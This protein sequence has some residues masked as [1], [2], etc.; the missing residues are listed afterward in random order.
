MRYIE[1]IS[2]K[3]INIKARIY[4]GEKSVNE[5]IYDDI[6]NLCSFKYINGKFST[7]LSEED[8][9]DIFNIIKEINA[10]IMLDISKNSF[11]FVSNQELQFIMIITYYQ[12]FIEYE[13]YSSTVKSLD[14]PEKI[15]KLQIYSQTFSTIMDRSLLYFYIIG[16]K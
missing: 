15:S 1:E 9:K 12:G 10:Y 3:K 13:I 14:I 6:N 7:I 2:E 11:L 4:G 8:L 16:L 5:Q